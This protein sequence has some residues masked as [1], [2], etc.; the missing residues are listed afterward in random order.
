MAIIHTFH[1]CWGSPFVSWFSRFALP[2]LMSPGNVP[3]LIAAGHEVKMTVFTNQ[4]DMPAIIEAGAF[5]GAKLRVEAFQLEKPATLRAVQAE[6]LITAATRAMADDAYFVPASAVTIWADGSLTNCVNV[7]MQTDC[8]V[9]AMYLLADGEKMI[10]EFA[11]PIDSATLAAVVFDHLHPGSR[12]T[13]SATDS[14]AWMYGLGMM[15][16]SPT[17]IATRIQV[18]SIAAIRFKPQDLA[19][20]K[21]END[22]RVWDSGLPA[23][24]IREGRFTF[25]ASSDLAFQVNLMRTGK[26]NLANHAELDAKLG[27][28]VERRHALR[29]TLQG[30]A[31]R[32]FLASIRT[33]RAV[34]L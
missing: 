27:P 30:E 8:A 29:A 17:L 25:L 16:L 19:L 24:L 18:P 26:M 33:S 3:A 15:Q 12:S 11:F 28:S 5:H 32:T 10:G 9:A 7:A 20:I 6:L 14:K 31:G 4:N 34:T 13:L 23:A 1:M 21:L 22:F 2:S